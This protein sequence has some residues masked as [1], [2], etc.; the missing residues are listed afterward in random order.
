M[1]KR[2]KL[3][4]LSA[5]QSVALTHNH[6]ERQVTGRCYQRSVSSRLQ[7]QAARQ[8]IKLIAVPANNR[9]TITQRR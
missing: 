4:K 8:S 2:F 5:D 7:F 1:I 9:V 6:A 3:L